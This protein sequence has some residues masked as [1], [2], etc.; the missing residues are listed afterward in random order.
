VVEYLRVLDHAGFFCLR[1]YRTITRDELMPYKKVQAAQEFDRWS[2]GYDRS[3]L[4]RLL[5]EP[6][7]R[8]IIARIGA[9]SGD[10]PLA[11]LDVG[12]GTGVFASRRGVG[13]T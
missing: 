1:W 4:Q 7:H 11:I 8:A 9:R 2:Q 5:F 3:V 13:T 6:S 10:R 12:C